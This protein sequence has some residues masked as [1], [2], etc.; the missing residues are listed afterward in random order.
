MAEQTMKGNPDWQRQVSQLVAIFPPMTIFTQCSVRTAAK[1]S[2]CERQ[3]WLWAFLSLPFP[4]L[5]SSK[6]SGKQGHSSIS[7]A[8]LEHRMLCALLGEDRQALRA[9]CTGPGSMGTTCGRHAVHHKLS[10]PNGVLLTTC[11]HKLSAH[12]SDTPGWLWRRPRL[13]PWHG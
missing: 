6:A 8:S 5:A 7:R 11:A 4:G 2:S 3:G 1:S 12:G 9:C 13:D 10:A